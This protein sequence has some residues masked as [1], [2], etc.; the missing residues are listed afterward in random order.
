MH[1]AT[2]T[3]EDAPGR[4][5]A[6]P[7]GEAI[8]ALDLGTNNCRLLIARAAP[9]GFRVV[10]AFSRIVRLGEGLARNGR[11]SPR[12]V[13]RGLAALGICADRMRRLAVARSRAVATEA[14]R[15]AADFPAFRDAAHARTGID[16]EVISPEEEARLALAGCA[17][18]LDPL[19]PCAVVFDIGGGSIEFVWLRVA[20]DGAG[21]PRVAEVIDSISLP[22]GVVSLA[23]RFGSRGRFA[24]SD[25]EAIIAD[26]TAQLAAFERRHG[27]RARIAAGEVQMLGSSGTMTTVAGVAMGLR[28]YDRARV[29]GAVVET[30]EAVAVSRRLLALGGRARAAH[31]CIGRRRA[32]LVVPGCAVLEAVCRLWPV[33]ALG[34]ADRGLREGILLDLAVGRPSAA[35]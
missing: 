21:R 17:A 26:T 1:P 29:D 15:R 23:E 35:G 30:A 27:I 4:H 12:A 31:P 16:L 5:D 25:Y 14:G 28:R 11:L 10:E 34:V 20:P 22:F 2:R 7:G 32:D 18:L 24:A 8:A 9:D 13:D 33:P 19:V 3:A 6:G